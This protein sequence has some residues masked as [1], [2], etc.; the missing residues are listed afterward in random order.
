[1]LSDGSATAFLVLAV[2]RVLWIP[3]S[4]E[5]HSDPTDRQNEMSGGWHGEMGAISLPHEALE[6][7][8]AKDDLAAEIIDIPLSEPRTFALLGPGLARIA[9]TYYLMK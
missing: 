1:M 5:L 3:V 9:R 8:T 6:C 2:I 4:S 7:W